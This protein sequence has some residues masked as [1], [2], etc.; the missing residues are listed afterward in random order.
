L[1][2]PGI[3]WPSFFGYLSDYQLGGVVAFSGVHEH[4]EEPEF[5]LAWD[6]SLVVVLAV[7]VSCPTCCASCTYRSERG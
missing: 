4:C 7:E 2:L 6:D 1:P 3:P 5:D